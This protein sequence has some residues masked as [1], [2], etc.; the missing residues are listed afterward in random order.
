M[1]AAP[2]IPNLIVIRS[3]DID[4]AVTFYETIGMLF[5]RHSHGKGPEHYASETCGFVFEIYPQRNGSANTANTRLGFSVDSVD[6]I[7]GLLESLD[8]EVVSPAKDSQWG[9][10]AVVRD[11]DGHTVELVTPPNREESIQ[12]PYQ[13]KSVT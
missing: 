10:R 6:D 12:P 9:R 13:P 8:V 11:L 3:P 1:H 4:R 5:E 2:P 7:L